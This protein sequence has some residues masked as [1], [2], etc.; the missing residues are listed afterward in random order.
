MVH[1]V[2]KELKEL[3]EITGQVEVVVHKVLKETKV[4]KVLRE[5]KVVMVQVVR[6]EHLV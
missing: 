1:K 2:P 4:H 3:K 6:V 5:L